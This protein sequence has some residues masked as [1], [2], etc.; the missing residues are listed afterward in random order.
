M[1]GHGRRIIN[2]PPTFAPTSFPF[3]STTAGSTPKNGSVALPGFVGIAPGNGVIMIAP[4]SVCHQVSTIGQRPP[5]TLSRYHIHAS[6]LI[7]SPTEPSRRSDDKSCFFSHW[8][9]QRVKAG[10]GGGA[11]EC[12]FAT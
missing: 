12:M 6:G 5:P 8:S 7:G 2:F 1:D 9:P 11:V 10:I 4:V 3:G